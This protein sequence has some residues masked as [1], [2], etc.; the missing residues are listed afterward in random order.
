MT[1]VRAYL[2]YFQGLAIEHVQINDFFVMDIN[3]P[4]AAL[5]GEMKFPA[6]IMNTLSG[7]FVAPNRDNILD[8]VKAGFLIIDRL[9]NVD[10]F[11]SEMLLLQNMK[12]I[13]TDIIARMNRDL[14]KCE[15][16]AIKAFHG[17]HF[18]S[19]S[20]QMID[21]IFDN[22]FG[23]LFTFKVF[24]KMNLDY[25]PLKWVPGIV[26]KDEFTY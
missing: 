21:G 7:H 4:L 25:D 9:D 22:C 24:S 18:S 19:V 17:F 8:E 26:G 20:Y 5:R 13:G 23:F 16:S 12:Q 14:I 11:S 15:P 3:E 6:L 10:D 2:H 1:D